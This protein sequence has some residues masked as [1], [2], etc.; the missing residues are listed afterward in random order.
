MNHEQSD[1]TNFPEPDPNRPSSWSETPS[2]MLIPPTAAGVSLPVRTLPAV[3]PLGQLSWE[4]FERLCLSLIRLDGEPIHAAQFGERGQA[5]AGIDIFARDKTPAGVSPPERRYVCLQ[6]RRI[7]GV[8]ETNLDEAVNRFLAGKWAPVSRAFIY[9]TSASTRSSH[10]VLKVESLAACLVER[11]IEFLVWNREEISERLRSQ[12]GLV[13]QFFGRSWVRSFCGEDAAERLGTRLDAQAVAELRRDLGNLY[14][15]VF[16]IADPGYIALDAKSFKPM[17]LRQRFVTPDLVSM[18]AQAASSPRT[19]D[20][21]RAPVEPETDLQASPYWEAAARNYSVTGEGNWQVRHPTRTPQHFVETQPIEHRPAVEWLGSSPLQTV[22]GEPGAGKSTLLRYLVLDL[23]S[24][25]PTCRVAADRWGQFL[26]VWLPFHFFTQR[27]VGR[28]GEQASVER[29]LQAWLDQRSHGQ[30]WPVVKQ[31]IVDRRLLLVVDGLDEWVNDDAGR[32][33]FAE[34]KVF[35]D[36]RDVPIVASTRPYGFSRLALDASWSYARIAPLTLGQQRQ[37]A[38]NFLRGVGRAEDH[39]PSGSIES[40]ADEFLS[41]LHEA[42]DVRALSGTP[43]FLILLL[44]LHLS[45]VTKLPTDRFQA[46][47]RAVQLLVADHP[48]QRRTAAAAVTEF[49]QRLSDDEIRRTLA[50]VAFASQERGDLSVIA[51]SSLRQDFISALKDSDDLAMSASGAAETSQRLLTVAEGE[52]GLLVREGPEEMSFLH[53]VFQEQLAAEYIANRL[54][55]SETKTLFARRVG[56]SQWREVLLATMWNIRR[57]QELRALADVIQNC[58]DETPAGLRARETLAELLFGPYGVPAIEI[59]RKAGH[60][61]DVIET[62]PYGPH[63]TRLLDSLIDGLEGAATAAIVEECLQRW[64]ILIEEPTSELVEAIAKVPVTTGQPNQVVKLLLRALLY[65][66]IN[67]AYAAATSIARRCATEGLGTDDERDLFRRGLLRLLSELPSGLV[68]ASAL[69]A[70]ALEWPNDP[71]VAEV[72]EQARRHGNSHI[73]LVALSNAAGVLRSEFSPAAQSLNPENEPLSS[74]EREWLVDHFHDREYFDVHRGLLVA[75]VAHVVS[76]QPQLVAEMVAS[77]SSSKYSVNDRYVDSD[78]T[79]SV[80]LRAFPNNPTV[81]ELVCNQLRSDEYSPLTLRMLTGDHILLGRAY[82]PDSPCNAQVAE[83]IEERLLKFRSEFSDW[84]LLGLAAVDRGPAMKSLLIE[85]A[86]S[87][88]WPHWAAGALVDYFGD[89]VESRAAL[90]SVLMGDPVRASMIANAAPKALGLDEA[91]PRLLAILRSL[92]DL[93]HPAA[94]RYDI[95]V[96]ALIEACQ[97]LGLTSGSEFDSIAA[98]ALALLPTSPEDYQGNPRHL[99]AATLYPSPAS[100]S[101]LKELG[102]AKSRNLAPRIRA[103][104]N[105]AARV[106]ALLIDASAILCSV[107]PYLRGRI[108]EALAGGAGAPSLV[109]DLTRRWSDEVSRPNV[110]IASL[111]YHRALEKAREKGNV[112]EELLRQEFKRLKE[113][114]SLRG[115]DHEPKVRGAWVGACVLGA[116]SELKEISDS[117]VEVSS[118]LDGPDRH[119]LMELASHWSD[120]RTEFGDELL[121]RFSGRWLDRKK[122]IWGALALVADHSPSLQLELEDAVAGDSALLNLDGVLAWF[123]AQSGS[124]T[125]AAADALVSNLRSRGNRESLASILIDYPEGIGLDRSFLVS[126]LEQAISPH[127]HLGDP[128]LQALAAICPKH[129]RVQKAWAEFRGERFFYFD[130]I[131]TYYAVAYA[132]ADTSEVLDLLDRHISRLDQLDASLVSGSFARNVARR[133]RRDESAAQLIRN[134]V[135]NAATSD[136]RA[137]TLVSL[138]TNAVGLD[139]HLIREVNRRLAE[140]FDAGL[141]PMARDYSVSGSPSV[142]IR[143]IFVR[144]VE[145]TAAIDPR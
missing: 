125:D 103:L 117:T 88:S 17:P 62:H 87:G 49:G 7:N 10:L 46:Y 96:L 16:S 137:A 116:F 104:R 14:G 133:L 71:K 136:S 114:A 106:G 28:T 23:L 132:A 129:E 40:A 70:L 91:I 60:I 15:S 66:D 127:S 131:R 12:P 64:A 80:L 126:R 89:D 124:Q 85:L 72:L 77:L 130:E 142:P 13:D 112:D 110:T 102:E 21:V 27:V 100:E 97:Q 37:L 120:L 19:L 134:E 113:T 42:S 122:E 34:L 43:L 98:E 99:L 94:G 79:W 93:G 115:M 76:G 139:E 135:L 54:S 48:A 90:R 1:N 81:I 6:A 92:S 51:V 101:S 47:D 53:R 38:V 119:L 4:D 105:D 18:S 32:A 36:S 11:S 52:I 65:P 95:V 59:R 69:T 145:G 39:S 3:L 26:P 35:A 109:M 30:L 33:A 111:A 82:P 9:A 24:N 143:N 8:T 56:D 67:V 63:R 2:W 29:T 123:V 121:E 61:V 118:L 141:A 31:A 20:N 5:Q 57:P 44:G 58:I 55:T 41:Q 108:C 73:R 68:G 74:D 138:L 107:P 75:S 86:A 140:Q 84:R 83:A 78:F 128:A 25:D 144:A 50:R 45:S 22:V